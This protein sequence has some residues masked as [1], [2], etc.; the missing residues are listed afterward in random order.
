M[1]Q[2]FALISGLSLMV[3]MAYAD[4]ILNCSDAN[5]NVVYKKGKEKSLLYK[6]NA[7][8]HSKLK[9][10]KDNKAM[11]AGGE[12]NGHFTY[13]A[14][15][16]GAEQDGNVFLICQK[17]DTEKSE[18]NEMELPPSYGPSTLLPSANCSDANGT[19]R[20]I[21]AIWYD[22][23]KPLASSARILQNLSVNRVVGA[24]NIVLEVIVVEGDEE[25][26][27]RFVICR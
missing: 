5:G 27:P 19:L 18:L 1:K 9:I 6:G 2:I 3:P 7:F 20:K 25:T 11:I 16:K 17:M 10:N 12:Y 8:K 4:K 13:S 24:D 15:V 14:H 23:N 21:G 22:H 26:P